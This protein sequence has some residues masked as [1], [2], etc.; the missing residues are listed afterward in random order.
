[1]EGIVSF[2]ATPKSAIRIT[3]EDQKTDEESI[4]R[5]LVAGGVAIP[6]RS[7]PQSETPITYR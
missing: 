2:G 5:A 7:T 1:M 6:G 3:Y 4:V